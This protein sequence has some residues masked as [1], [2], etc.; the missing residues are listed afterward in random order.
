MGRSIGVEYLLPVINGVQTLKDNSI[1]APVMCDQSLSRKWICTRVSK[2]VAEALSIWADLKIY[3]TA[4]EAWCTLSE[5]QPR[6]TAV[7]LE[8]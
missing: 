6:S 5:T 2:S 3:A 8:E 7:E 4:L 1:T